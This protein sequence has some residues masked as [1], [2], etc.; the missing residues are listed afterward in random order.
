LFTSANPQRKL[1]VFPHRLTVTF[2]QAQTHEQKG[3]GCE[4]RFK[5]GYN[6]APRRLVDV[7]VDVEL[8]HGSTHEA[9]FVHVRAE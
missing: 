6:S 4:L 1:A 9:T 7:D 2:T 5:R 3:N 8:A